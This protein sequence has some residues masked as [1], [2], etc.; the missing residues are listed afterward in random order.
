MSPG[1][2]QTAITSLWDPLCKVL[3]EKFL[4]KKP[5]DYKPTRSFRNFPNAIGA[6]DATLMATVQPANKADNDMWFSGKH[7]RHG[8]KLQVISAPD[9]T[10]IHFGGIIPGRRNDEFLFGQSNVSRA[11]SQTVTNDNG[12]HIII[13]PPIL[14]DGGYQGIH[15]T[16]PEA[17]MPHR[18]PPHG[19]LTPEQKHENRLIPRIELSS[20]NSLDT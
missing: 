20:N 3:T 6:L 17:I 18:K 15:E 1:S 9:G 5:G 13:R 12:L 10:V 11:L 14:V 8:A 4:P 16:Y 7:Q 19:H 2:I